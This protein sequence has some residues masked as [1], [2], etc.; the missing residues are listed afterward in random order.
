M[1]IQLPLSF[2]LL[3]L[4]KNDCISFDKKLKRYVN[5]EFNKWQQF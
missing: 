1:A 4:F 3:S 2:L 5:S